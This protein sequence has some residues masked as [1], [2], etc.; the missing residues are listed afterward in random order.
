MPVKKNT[1]DSVRGGSLKHSL[2][3]KLPLSI[4][5]V[6]LII[7]SISTA[8]ILYKAESVIAF[9]KSSRIEDAALTVGQN[10]SVQLQRVSK[11]MILIA[12]FPSVLQGLELPVDDS[13]DQN[14]AIARASLTAMLNRVKVAFGYYGSFALINGKGEIVA[15]SQDRIAATE[16]VVEQDW[17]QK[18][19]ETNTLVFSDP[20]V[21]TTAEGVVLPMSLKTVYNGKVGCLVSTLQV[22]RIARGILHDS[23]RP[24][25]NSYIVDARGKILAALDKAELGATS[26]V[27]GIISKGFQ[28]NVSGS[29]RANL[30]GE[31]KTI[32]FYHI[33]QTQL[34]AVVIAD[35]DYMKSYLA[36][37][38]TSTLTA[39][40]ATALLAAGCVCLFIFPVTG[41]IKKLS[42]FARDIARGGRDALTGVKRRDELGDLALSLSNM[43]AVLTEA[44]ARANAATTAKSE[45]LARMSHEIRT[46]M[47]GII[48]MTYLAMRKNPNDEQLHFLR[49]I[50]GAAKNLLGVINDILDFSKIEANKMELAH[51]A[52]TLSDMLQ[53][54]YDLISVKARE[55]NIALDFSTADG[56]PEVLE[57]DSLRL[58]QILINICSNALKFTDKGSV[59]LY[60]SVKEERAEGV[61]LAFTVK[62]TGIGMDAEAQR[63]IFDS[64]SQADGSITRR[65]GGTGLGLAICK[66]LVQMMGGELGVESALGE[67]STFHFTAVLGVG[68]EKDVVIDSGRAADLADGDVLSSMHILLAEDNELNQEIALGVLEAL[69]MT[70]V[71]ADNGAEAVRM[72]L[73]EDFALILMDIQMPVMD[74]LAATMR[75]RNSGRPRAKTIPIIAMTANAMQGDREK[76]LEAGMNDHITKPLD[77]AELRA[78]LAHWGAFGDTVGRLKADLL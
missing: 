49:S 53:S 13:S 48:G 54:V 16:N 66:A 47:N 43:V 17:F 62:D 2:R 20:V 69:G 73:Q 63:R 56:V 64:F 23:Q 59:N 18:T 32:G 39:G 25:V 10:I 24:G 30:N 31:K 22:S 44:V 70:V 55:K 5:A 28:E 50:D 33:P 40:L 6:V 14:A 78:V 52:F 65:Y 75:I 12:G 57:G 27:G 15:G 29:L 38:Q 68:T 74:G 42:L 3:V 76:S 35:A 8:Y 67:G 72:W 77:M 46:P 41:D 61:L 36:E 19:L 60:V 11:D 37:M 71:I 7:L 21:S 58:S 26:P 9:V 4:L 45:F 51:T 1:D 34:Y